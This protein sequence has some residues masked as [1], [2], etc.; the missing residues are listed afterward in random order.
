MFNEWVKREQ[1][2]RGWHVNWALSVLAENG[3]LR[4][5]FSMAQGY[6]MQVLGRDPLNESA[7]QLLVKILLYAGQKVSALSY[8]RQMQRRLQTQLG[9]ALSA[10][11]QA[12]L[13]TINTYQPDEINIVLPVET[14]P[15][16]GRFAE[17][18]QLSQLLIDPTYRCI[19]LRGEGGI[20]KTRLAQVVSR[21]VHRAFPDGVYAIT[22]NTLSADGQSEIVSDVI[23]EAIVDTLLGEKEN[24]QSPSTTLLSHLQDQRI[25]LN[26]C[27]SGAYSQRLWRC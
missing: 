27:F 13:T 25:L 4:G 16:F 21:Q 5:G 2:I 24:T 3:L 8:Y 7:F 11:S 23:A 26:L 17:R 20:G 19:M 6:I 10:E 14:T 12:L 1:E 22:F 15:F 18:H 9:S